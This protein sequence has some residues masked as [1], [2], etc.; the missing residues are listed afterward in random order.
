MKD[1]IKQNL[2]IHA[3]KWTDRV[4]LAAAIGITGIAIYAAVKTYD[5][6]KK[7]FDFDLDVDDIDWDG[8]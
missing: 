5:V 2:T 7:K 1:K 8:K 6:V 4:A 3:G